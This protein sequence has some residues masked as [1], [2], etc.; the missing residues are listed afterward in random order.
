MPLYG[1]AVVPNGL[2]FLIMGGEDYRNQIYSDKVYQYTAD[3]TWKEMPMTLSE[4]KKY[5]TAMT[6]PS[7]PLQDVKPWF[8]IVLD[9]LTAIFKKP[10]VP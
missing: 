1:S 10:Q 5:F 7:S 3:G 6:V 9:I 2:T 8:N 4:A